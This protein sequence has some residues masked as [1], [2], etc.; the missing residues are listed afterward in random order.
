MESVAVF[1][2]G[3]ACLSR[4]L[5]L[6]RGPLAATALSFLY[7]LS[8]KI[9]FYTC[10][11]YDDSIVTTLLDLASIVM[12]AL[13]CYAC[14]EAQLLGLTDLGV[15]G[16]LQ[17]T[18]GTVLA[19][20]LALLALSLARRLYDKQ[21]R[22]KRFSEEI[23][24]GRVYLVTGSNTGL[25]YE[26]TKELARMGGV[27]VMACRSLDKA[28]AA[29]ESLLK[30]LSSKCK[31]SQLVVLPAGLDLN[32]FDSV[33]AFAADFIK[34]NLPLHCLVNNAG[35]MMSE[36]NVTRDGLE[37]VM[38]ANHLSAFL[39]T[40][41][42]V[43]ALEAGA[44]KFKLCSRI[45][46]VSSS[47]HHIPKA[48]NF[49]DVMSEKHYELFA[50]YAQSK[51][52]NILFTRELQKRLAAKNLQIT[53]NCLHPGFV[54]TEV[55]RHM[56]AFLF[57]GDKLA[58]PIMLTLQKTPSQGAYC[59]LHVATSPTLERR[60]GLYFVN[61]DEAEPSAGA[62]SGNDAARLWTLSEE[63]TRAKWL[64]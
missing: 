33:R 7:C 16:G 64:V 13:G 46:N 52:A 47:L 51:L 43:P 11:D 54:R 27:V 53:A 42:L 49:D 22:G 5:G 40:S 24:D 48:F 41:L 32:S 9:F 14:G 28:N 26:T 57:W 8:L 58:T 20:A 35:L 44:K 60:G 15:G 1:A 21:V 45:V 25:G 2:L 3:V 23:L 37:M 63:L 10:Y 17:L 50:T 19:H 62:T 4:G 30:D 56:S 18:V 39:L 55:T 38:T 59:T 31:P 29:R 36:R 6:E 34:L 61:C 12:C